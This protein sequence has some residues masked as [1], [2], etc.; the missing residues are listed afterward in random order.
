MT[1]QFTPECCQINIFLVFPPSDGF[2]KTCVITLLFATTVLN[3]YIV[4]SEDKIMPGLHVKSC[5]PGRPIPGYLYAFILGIRAYLV[6][7]VGET[8]ADRCRPPSSTVMSLDRQP[9]VV[10]AEVACGYGQNG[11]V[12]TPHVV[13]QLRP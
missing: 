10:D 2:D 13:E 3:E 4:Y 6:G 5:I 9:R 8:D 11:Y 7:I 1:H 12:D